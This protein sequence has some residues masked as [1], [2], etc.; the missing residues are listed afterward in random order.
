MR[1]R[2]RLPARRA[3]VPF[4]LAALAALECGGGCGGGNTGPDPNAAGQIKVGNDGAEIAP[5]AAGIKT[6]VVSK[7]YQTWTADAA[8]RD[9]TQGSPHG[10]VRVFFNKT[11]TDALRASAL[12]L[13]VGAMLV[14]ERYDGNGTSLN[15]YA[16]MVKTSAGAWTWW[17]ASSSNPDT[18]QAFGVGNPSCKGCHSA[19]GNK[20]QVRSSVP[21]A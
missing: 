14:K 11:A 4:A 19:S 10:K 21:G 1:F 5:S 15:G 6:Y 16:A 18:P 7:A 9:P 2:G 3:G 8:V 20:D 12:P 13:P 17:E